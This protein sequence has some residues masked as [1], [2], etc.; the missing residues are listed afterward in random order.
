M[1]VMV[2]FRDPE[3]PRPLAARLIAVASQH[4]RG[5]SVST[6]E[7]GEVQAATFEGCVSAVQARTGLRR[8]L[9]VWTENRE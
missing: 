7:G 9:I 2:T 4:P 5:W 3:E 1:S 8:L 6:P